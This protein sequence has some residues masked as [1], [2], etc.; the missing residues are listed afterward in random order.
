MSSDIC[1]LRLDFQNFDLTETAPIDG[2]CVDNF[3]ITSGSSR[4]YFKL[5]GTLSG[6]HMY[7]ETGRATTDQVATFTIGATST[8]A[9]WRVKVNQIECHSTSKAPADCMQ[10][11]T[12]ISGGISSLNYP[13]TALTDIAYTICVRRE[14]GFCGIEWAESAISSPDAFDLDAGAA[15]DALVAGAVATASDVYI[16]IPGSLNGVYGGLAFSDGTSATAANIDESSSSVQAFGMPFTLGVNTYDV[17]NAEV[18]GFNL[19]YNQI[20]CGAV[21]HLLISSG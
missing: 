15:A 21:P 14:Y 1:Q 10:Y 19:I 3:D 9:T 20:A 16:T 2:T 11:L 12:G 18:M 6:Q 17:A 5:C 13:T 7:V 8:V 4:D